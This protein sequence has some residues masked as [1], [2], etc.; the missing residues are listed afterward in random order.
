MELALAVQDLPKKVT[1][2]DFDNSWGQSRCFTI[3][4]LSFCLVESHRY[5]L[6]R[7][8]A[9]LSALGANDSFGGINRSKSADT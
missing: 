3:G 8:D 2:L 9:L 7:A 4:S 6:I 1:E 5:N